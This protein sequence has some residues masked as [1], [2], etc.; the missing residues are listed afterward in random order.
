MLFDL[1]QGQ[2]FVDVFILFFGFPQ[3]RAALKIQVELQQSHEQTLFKVNEWEQGWTKYPST[4]TSDL[5]GNPSKLH[6][7]V[8]ETVHKIR[9]GHVFVDKE[10]L[11]KVPPFL[12]GTNASSIFLLKPWW[13]SN[14]ILHPPVHAV[15]EA[16]P[17]LNGDVSLTQVTD[18]CFLLLTHLLGL[19]KIGAD[20]NP[21]WRY[22]RNSNESAILEG[23]RANL[24]VPARQGWVVGWTLTRL[25]RTSIASLILVL[26]LVNMFIFSDIIC[27]D[28][29]WFSM[30]AR[31]PKSNTEPVQ[32][33]FWKLIFELSKIPENLFVEWTWRVNHLGQV[34]LK[35]V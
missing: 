14:R 28:V 6:R 15:V 25:H 22:P 1:K 20:S 7:I 27:I 26:W 13:Q 17:W 24:R 33:D 23:Y 32:H 35:P 31:I 2:L 34:A 19:S 16:S 9:Y 18:L 3:S 11:Q 10:L 4:T 5:R 29:V 12:F 8:R 30:G 21:S